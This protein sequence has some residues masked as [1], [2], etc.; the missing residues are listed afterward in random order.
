M[1]EGD[2]DVLDN[3]YFVNF[4]QTQMKRILDP[5]ESAEIVRPYGNPGEDRPPTLD[6][7]RSVPFGDDDTEVRRTL[8]AQSA[9][10]AK[11]AVPKLH[12]AGNP[13]AIAAVGGRRRDTIG[14]YP[15]LTIADVEGGHWLPLDD[16]HAMGEG[17]AAWLSTAAK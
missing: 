15:N 8:E 7:P 17:L 16:P 4:S 13:G 6:W 9:W 12:I 1:P 5:Q 11:S 10:L 14:A 2:K 3:N